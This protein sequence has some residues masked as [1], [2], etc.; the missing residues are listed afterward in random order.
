MDRLSRFTKDFLEFLPSKVQALILGLIDEVAG[1][2]QSNAQLSAENEKL[3]EQVRELEGQKAKNSR[4]S[5]KPPS[6]DGPKKQNQ[7]ASSKRTKNGRVTGGQKGHPGST[8]TAVD[9]PD[10][11]VEIYPDRCERCE[12]NLKGQ[13]P[14]RIESRQEFEIPPLEIEVTE[15]RVGHI[16]CKCGHENCGEFPGRIT[17]PVQYGTGFK[18]LAVYLQ[19]YQL[20]PFERT[21]EFFEDIFGQKISEGTLC[22]IKNDC[23]ERLEKTD[24]AIKQSVLN[25]GVVG[26]DETGVRCEKKNYWIHVASTVELTHF[27][28]DRLR[29][30][31]AMDAHGVVPLFQGVGVHD[32]LRAYFTY[33]N[34]DHALCNAHHL[35]ELTFV[36]EVEQHGWG[37]DMK[38][39]LVEVK[40][41]VSAAKEK[42]RSRLSWALVESFEARYGQI[43]AQGTLCYSKPPPAPGPKKR[44]RKKQPKGKNLLDRLREH[45]NETLAFMHNFD[46]PFD[47]NLCERDLRMLKSQQKISGCFRSQHGARIYCRIRGYISSAKKQ[48]YG[49]FKAIQAVFQ[50]KPLQLVLP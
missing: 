5:S 17:A 31:E 9:K 8:L 41:T 3:K 23:F 32:G 35:R 2:K 30:T 28:F 36:E 27:H 38:S 47:N 37:K 26:F 29:G 21:S 33:E 48:D 19:Q 12:R 11:V 20:M 10:H 46:V 15:Y 49:V 22:N 18:A 42:G 45:Q 6:S 25:S 50:G 43:L 14:N 34:W 7:K 13:K 24:D 39:L 1:L 44:G 16:V 4:N 40:D